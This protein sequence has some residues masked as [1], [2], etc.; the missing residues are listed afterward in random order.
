MSLNQL[1]SACP[2][3]SYANCRGAISG[4][5]LCGSAIH[6][7]DGVTGSP[8]HNVAMALLGAVKPAK[9]PG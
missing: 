7:G 2:M 1:F 6:R 8:R 5:Y 9:E 3:L 4:L